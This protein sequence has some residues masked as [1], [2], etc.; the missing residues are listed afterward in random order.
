MKERELKIKREIEKQFLKPI[1][2]SI[3]HMDKLEQKKKKKVKPVKNTFY[4]WLINYIPKSIRKSAGGFEDEI[5]KF[6]T[7][8]PKQNVHETGMKLSKPKT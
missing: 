3:D 8:T 2:L 6:K 7:N 5:V 1:L 4:N